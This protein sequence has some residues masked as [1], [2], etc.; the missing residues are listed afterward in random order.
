MIALVLRL[1]LGLGL[2]DDGVSG[3]IVSNV[4]GGGFNPY[5]PVTYGRVAPRP[6]WAVPVPGWDEFSRA[7]PYVEIVVGVAIVLGFFTTYTASVAALMPVLVRSL[8]V[9][10]LLLAGTSDPNLV[11]SLLPF[12]WYE[13]GALPNLVVAVAVVW[14]S[15]SGDDRLS[16]DALIWRR[17]R[18]EEPDLT[19]VSAAPPA[20]V[21]AGQIP[22]VPAVGTVNPVRQEFDPG[23][24]LEEAAGPR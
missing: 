2:L 21:T 3:Y 18:A 11:N 7:L 20:E 6:P 8:K 19:P 15:S 16:L 14:L 10:Y 24:P 12:G 13:Q 4:G 1:T 5:N 9:V 23:L 22:D 17:T